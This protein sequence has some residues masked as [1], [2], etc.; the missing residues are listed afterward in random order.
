VNYE[1]PKSLLETPPKRRA[2]KTA[3]KVEE[4]NFAAS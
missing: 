4:L 2:T 1:Y 3:G